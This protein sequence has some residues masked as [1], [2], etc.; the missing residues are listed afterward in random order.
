MGV[1]P[2]EGMRGR[3][4]TALMMGTI[5]TGD[6]DELNITVSWG[7]GGRE[8]EREREKE[9][10]RERERERT[11]LNP[12]SEAVTLQCHG[13]IWFK[14]I[15]SDKQPVNTSRHSQAHSGEA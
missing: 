6:V 14:R 15:Q 12:E 11:S 1:T 3:A 8:R 7:W 9:R 10:E 2:A 5:T 4:M 13:Y